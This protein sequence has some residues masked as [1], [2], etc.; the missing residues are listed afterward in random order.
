M[1]TCHAKHLSYFSPHMVKITKSNYLTTLYHFV[2]RTDGPKSYLSVRCDDVLAAVFE[3][4]VTL[5]TVIHTVTVIRLRNVSSFLNIIHSAAGVIQTWELQKTVYIYNLMKCKW[6]IINF[7]YVLTRKEK[8]LRS[9][10]L[11]L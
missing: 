4:L 1:F 2:K 3:F 8:S 10:T 11:W 9:K 6:Y 7:Y 5:V